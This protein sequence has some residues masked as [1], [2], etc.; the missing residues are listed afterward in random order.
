MLENLTG[1][2]LFQ[3]WVQLRCRLELNHEIGTGVF[4]LKEPTKSPSDWALGLKQFIR[5][6]KALVFNFF[7][8]TSF[9]Q[10]NDE[11]FENRSW[12][13]KPLVLEQ[14]SNHGKANKLITRL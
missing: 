4:D 2:S 12:F 11:I 6:T 5:E 8:G 1:D 14:L 10:E 7:F 9:E 3:Q 13:K